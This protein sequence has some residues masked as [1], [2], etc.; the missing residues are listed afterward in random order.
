MEV[1]P[2]RMVMMTSTLDSS[3]PPSHHSTTQ[4]TRPV[5]GRYSDTQ[6][7]YSD[8]NQGVRTPRHQNVETTEP[9]VE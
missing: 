7:K 2:R 9:N 4:D 3:L 1:G 5:S 8:Y 6:S